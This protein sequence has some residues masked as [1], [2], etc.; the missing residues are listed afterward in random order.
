MD[1]LYSKANVAHWR[2]TAY[3]VFSIVVLIAGILVG[4]QTPTL[5]QPMDIVQ[6]HAN[7]ASVHLSRY[8]HWNNAEYLWTVSG[9]GIIADKPAPIT[10][11]ARF[12]LTDVSGIEKPKLPLDDNPELILKALCGIS[13]VSCRSYLAT[14]AEIAKGKALVD[15]TART[16]DAEGMK[17][18]RFVPDADVY[19]PAHEYTTVVRG[20]DVAGQFIFIDR[21]GEP[22]NVYYSDNF[23]G[24]D[25]TT[26]TVQI[27]RKSPELIL[28]NGADVL[29]DDALPNVLRSQTLRLGTLSLAAV[30][31]GAALSSAEIVR[32]R[33]I[34]N[35]TIESIAVTGDVADFEVRRRDGAALTTPAVLRRYPTTSDSLAIEFRFVPKST[36]NKEIQVRVYC[37]DTTQNVDGVKRYFL[38]TVRGTGTD[39]RLSVV[40]A[41]D[42]GTLRVGNTVDT[43]LVVKSTGTSPA[44][45]SYSTP[46]IPF[47]ITDARNYSNPPKPVIGLAQGKVDSVRITFTPLTFGNVVDSVV[48]ANGN[49]QR[50]V[51]YL[52]GR[53][54]TSGAVILADTLN[55]TQDTIDFGITQA[56][57]PVLRPFFVRNTGN[58]LLFIEEQVGPYYK[59]ENTPNSQSSN[60]RLEFVPSFSFSARID[61]AAGEKVT[62]L[63]MKFNSDA[64]TSVFPTGNIEA[65]L[66]IGVAELAKT[67]GG[68]DT[69]RV[70]TTRKLVLVARKVEA[71]PKVKER[72]DFDSVYVNCP[73][74]SSVEWPVTNASKK[75]MSL[76][77][78]RIE[79]LYSSNGIPFSLTGKNY[80]VGLQPN[81]TD[82]RHIVYT[83]TVRGPDTARY[84]LF[85]I[86]PS[87]DS[88]DVLVSGVGVEQELRLDSAVK[89]APSERYT[90]RQDT[91]DLGDV[92]VCSV[93]PVTVFLSNKGNLPFRLR[94][95]GQKIASLRFP[96]TRSDFAQVV[97]PFRGSTIG[98]G[99]TARILLTVSPYESGE[100]VL[101]YTL[102]SDITTR[103]GIK[104]VP[105][106]ASAKV[107]YIRFRAI[108]PRLHVDKPTLDFGTML[109]VQGCTQTKEMDIRVTNTG[110]S[111]LQ[112]EQPKVQHG[113]DFIALPASTMTIAP[114]TSAVLTVRFSPP[115]LGVFRDTLL[116]VS[117]SGCPSDTM[118]VAVV[119]T[120]VPPQPIA[121]SLPAL[122]RTRPGRRIA[123]PIV[124][125]SA[126]YLASVQKFSTTLLYDKSLLV[127]AGSYSTDGTASEKASSSDITISENPRG[128]LS[129]DIAHPKGV[130]FSPRPTLIVLLFDTYLGEV[131]YTSVGFR[132][133]EFSD[134]KCSGLL[135]ASTERGVVALDS[136]C[137]LESLI[138][139]PVAGVFRL[140]QNAPNPVED[141]AFINFEVAFPT[142]VRL[143]VY[144]N[145]G[146]LV[147]T[148]A[149]GWHLPGQYRMRV[150]L[151]LLSSGLYFYEMRA[152]I[153]RQVRQMYIAK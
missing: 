136:V 118:R 47:G 137:N 98:I 150:P 87:R 149:D 73:D 53:G 151:E 105:A 9:S 2:A 85:Y 8:V 33:G 64:L 32:N 19:N 57:D 107:L 102:P 23:T 77:G 139:P 79:L 56:G 41:I 110:N 94:S 60:D 90:I 68:K 88:V 10:V 91:I 92:Q 108:H 36:G 127:Y 37:N 58:V 116:L 5:A 61:T 119:A 18:F 100:H 104:C 145:R 69:L 28:T 138:G 86:P 11:D 135:T 133:T 114:G 4:M 31:S 66:T 78:Q 52:R 43:T 76:E 142:S 24:N 72:I 34:D 13:P 140:E 46:L 89:N 80:P 48:L 126:A 16:L 38:F 101:R 96:G 62:A 65:Y 117:N 44:D 20:R 3:K 124:V 131:A 143:A 70:I 128:T 15:L 132:S 97:T 152:G 25:P 14:N 40:D 112:V 81:E 17:A 109:Y 71:R 30:A 123:L 75:I 7:K 144:N 39:T 83:P 121:V 95:D 141:E 26:F 113:A 129:I 51:V 67:Q 111:P 29:N 63:M 148:M 130:V 27:E 74:G 22:D 153:F 54:I 21:Y 49:T 103:E 42:F 125:D 1:K 12:S 82:V 122:V 45:F 59:V 115:A 35:L 120:A 106:S 146:E 147:A 93:Q 55:P 84:W 50:Y 99:D 6:V 134:D